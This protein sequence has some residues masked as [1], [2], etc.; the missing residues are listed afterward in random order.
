MDSRAYSVAARLS[1]SLMVYCSIDTL[2][3]QELSQS[4]SRN[5][6]YLWLR[7]AYYVHAFIVGQSGN[8][9]PLA[10]MHVAIAKYSQVRYWYIVSSC[11]KMMN[12]ERGSE[13]QLSDS[14]HLGEIIL[15]I[16]LGSMVSAVP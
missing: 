15:C 4:I 5:N 13:S 10:C 1:L 6:C 2:Y 8:Q 14:F 12:A 3:A 9:Y 16:H 7:M 11:T